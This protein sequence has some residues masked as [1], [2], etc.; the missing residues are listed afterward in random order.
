M[1]RPA[2]VPQREALECQHPLAAAVVRYA[3]GRCVARLVATGFLTNGAWDRGDADKEKI[4]EMFY[5]T[6]PG[7]SCAMGMF[8]WKNWW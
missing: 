2:I 4:F 3:D 5:S 6:R 1:R 7:G 8:R